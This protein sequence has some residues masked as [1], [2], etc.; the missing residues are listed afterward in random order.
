MVAYRP[1]PPDLLMR[2][3]GVWREGWVIL[4]L[5]VMV[6]LAL[7]V[8]LF[9]PSLTPRNL[10]IAAPYLALI[11]AIAL[12]RMHW[13]AQLLALLFFC[14]PFVIQF[15]PHN[16]NAGYWELADYMETNYDPGKD[17]L[18]VVAPQLW[19]WIPIKYF[20]DERTHLGLSDR[21]IFY[22]TP[23]VQF[24]PCRT[25]PITAWLR[26]TV[27]TAICSACRPIWASVT[28]CG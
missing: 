26:L 19:Q 6:G 15:R 21:D 8:N 12:R 20:L 3:G 14:L 22:V 16:G 17:R 1:F 18:V 10:L 4:S 11:A 24:L 9:A 13:Q 28:S 5:I 7:L 25:I 23:Q 27:G 2:F